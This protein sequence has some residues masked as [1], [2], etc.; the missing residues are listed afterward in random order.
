MNTLIDICLKAGQCKHALNV[1]NSFEK[2]DIKPSALTYGILIKG[3]GSLKQV[4][5]ALSIYDKM[6][7]DKIQINEITVG[8][9][10]DA[11]VKGGRM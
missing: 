5:N 1:F 4:D 3:F 7:S 2:N 10:I 6:I 8:C 9:L 11:C